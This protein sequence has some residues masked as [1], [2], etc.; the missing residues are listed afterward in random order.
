MS[1]TVNDLE[2]TVNSSLTT[3]IINDIL[4]T[5][6]IYQSRLRVVGQCGSGNIIL[7]Y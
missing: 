5:L 7:L 3:T 2:R 4:K 6:N 1:I